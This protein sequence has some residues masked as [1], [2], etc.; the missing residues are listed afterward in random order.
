M[1]QSKPERKSIFQERYLNK[2]IRVATKFLENSKDFFV[3]QGILAGF[4]NNFIYL[5]NV[6][7]LKNGKEELENFQ[8]LAL[9]KTLISYITSEV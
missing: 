6:K 1:N 9:N 8:D 2:K 3:Y 5:S 7:V 4:D